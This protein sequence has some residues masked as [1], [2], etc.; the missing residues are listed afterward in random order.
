LLVGFC[1][2][3]TDA[4]LEKLGA[5]VAE[6]SVPPATRCLSNEMR[7]AQASID[8][9]LGLMQALAE[10]QTLT[11]SLVT[12]DAEAYQRA[13]EEMGEMEAEIAAEL[14]G[15]RRGDASCAS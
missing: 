11:R 15:D 3:L 5:V 14:A 1:G 4:E 7:A 6:L 13:L 9:A 2:E 8:I 12:F 10:L